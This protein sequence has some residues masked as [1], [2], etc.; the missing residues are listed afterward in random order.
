V[1]NYVLDIAC[2]KN[3][4]AELARTSSLRPRFETGIIVIGVVT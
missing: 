4:I 1:V 3:G 2:P